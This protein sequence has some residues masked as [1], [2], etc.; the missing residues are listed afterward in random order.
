MPWMLFVLLTNVCMCV[1]LQMWANIGALRKK[2]QQKKT[3]S[4]CIFT[5]LQ[6]NSYFSLFFL[7]DC[8]CRMPIVFCFLNFPYKRV[9]KMWVHSC[10]LFEIYVYVCMYV[11]ESNL[12]IGIWRKNNVTMTTANSMSQHKLNNNNNNSKNKKKH[13]QVM[14]K[15]LRDWQREWTI[16]VLDSHII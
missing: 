15:T 14:W 3:V 12:R 2:K 5:Y 13:K 8:C 16:Y 7:P 6:N 11:Y 9:S 4:V 10:A 1:Q